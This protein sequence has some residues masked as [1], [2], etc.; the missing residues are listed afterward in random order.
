L[1]GIYACIAETPL[2][3][4]TAQK[5]TDALEEAIF[6]FL[7]KS[8]AGSALDIGQSPLKVS[9]PIWSEWEPGDTLLYTLIKTYFL[10]AVSGKGSLSLI[11]PSYL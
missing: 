5:L 8:P 6:A 10:Y 9:L 7:I 3:P 4:S 1:D 11:L 2:E